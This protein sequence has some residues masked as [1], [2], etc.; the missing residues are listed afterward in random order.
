MTVKELIEALSKL[1]PEAEVYI[2][3]PYSEDDGPTQE[4]EPNRPLRLPMGQKG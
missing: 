2:N 3:E 4:R 1:P